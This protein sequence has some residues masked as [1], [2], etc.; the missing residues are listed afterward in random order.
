MYI[1]VTHVCIVVII[2]II[3]LKTVFYVVI[4]AI[5]VI[6]RQALYVS[7][8]QAADLRI[9]LVHVLEYRGLEWW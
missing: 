4:V 3:Q 8:P 1:N 7:D 5:F 2:I 6:V 9:I